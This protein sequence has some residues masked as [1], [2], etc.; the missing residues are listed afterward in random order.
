M[1]RRRR[2]L[3]YGAAGTPTPPPTGYDRLTIKDNATYKYL[4]IN[5]GSGVYKNLV[6]KV[7]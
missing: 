2:R 3:I 5:V 1:A 6:V 7:A 4:T